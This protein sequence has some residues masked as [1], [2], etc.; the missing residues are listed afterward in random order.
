M[1]TENQSKK[2]VILG[3]GYAGVNAAL[4]LRVR[5]KAVQITLVNERGEFVERIRNHQNA[6]G[7]TLKRLELAQMLGE[8]IR[9][10]KGRAE[11]IDTA[12]KHVLVK[13]DSAIT[14]LP[15]DA[16]VYALGS[17]AKQAT[18]GI[19]QINTREEAEELRADL[20]LRKKDAVVIVGAGLSGLELATELREIYPERKITLVDRKPPGS[21]L[22]AKGQNYL[23]QV[24]AEMKIGFEVP[25]GDAWQIAGEERHTIVVDCTGFTS[26]DLARRSGFACDDKNR[27]LVNENLQ[28]P[29]HR[30][31][32]FAGDAAAYT[33]GERAI[34]YS[35][36][37][38]ASPMGTYTGEAVA[39]FL[40]GEALP[41][42]HYG[43][44]FQCI[45]LGRKK[46]IIQF[47]DKRT[48][49][50]QTRVLTGKPAAIFKE[51]ICKMTVFLPGW[52]RKTRWPFYTWRKTRLLKRIG[53][54]ASKA[55]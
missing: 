43:F 42:F 10:V 52:E 17:G 32:F 16:L 22:S 19:Y 14:A 47:L 18:K 8:S 1:N 29:G 7:E 35:G 33:F 23:N 25:A 9:F 34:T 50:A 44:T 55:A 12:G 37:A 27:V 4:R 20:A 13:T 2:V 38:T 26:P 40:A 48:G 11:K 30:E 6:A 31:I 39:K 49:L 41:E 54:M 45:S 28:V 3:G 51:L 46:G 24:L 15:Y 21:H 36:C 53:Q 5:D